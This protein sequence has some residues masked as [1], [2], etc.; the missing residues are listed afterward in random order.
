MSEALEGSSA[1]P[2]PDSSR[3]RWEG[4]AEDLAAL[5]APLAPTHS[6]L[7]YGEA[8]TVKEAAMQVKSIV[9]QATLLRT[10]YAEQANLSF[11]RSTVKEAMVALRTLK[12]AEW[13][14]S[15]SHYE[16]WET[17]MVKR[18][19]NFCHCAAQA[20]AK[21]RDWVMKLLGLDAEAAGSF[22]YGY[23]AELRQ[24]WRQDARD[25][26]KPKEV[27]MSLEAVKGCNFPIA[28][29]ADG[30]EAEIVDVSA[31]DFELQ[32]QPREHAKRPSKVYFEREHIETHHRLRGLCKMD[33]QMLF[34]LQEQSRQILQIHVSHFGEDSEDTREKAA[35]FMLRICELYASNMIQRSELMV[36]RDELM[37]ED[38]Y[39][40]RCARS[41]LRRLGSKSW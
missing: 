15:P 27:A 11:Q 10:L 41:L 24:A 1:M 33:R 8:E 22:K 30:S 7:K 3:S 6:F 37:N 36:K 4:K 5:L 25:P 20:I 14:L 2:S 17:T 29:F 18:F 19:M 26:K 35:K 40:K 23:S 13:T 38:G 12:V 31:E 16:D 32:G 9:E 28:R 21:K 34:I 39:K